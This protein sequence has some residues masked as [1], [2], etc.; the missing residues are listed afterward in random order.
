MPLSG[1]VGAMLESC[2]QFRVVRWRGPEVS[3]LGDITPTASSEKYQV[4]ITYRLGLPP[5]VYIVSPELQNAP[6]GTPTP[7]TYPGKRLCL[8][9]PEAKEWDSS[10]AIGRTMVPWAAL[11]L[12]FYEV[13]LA[14]GK[15]EGGGKHPAVGGEHEGDTV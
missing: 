10:M 5:Q 7:H 9:F 1:Q 15:W 12:Y 13:W 3:W 14:T 11:W 8:Y 6:D 2:P 4:R